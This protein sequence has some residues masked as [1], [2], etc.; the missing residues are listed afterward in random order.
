[1]TKVLEKIPKIELHE[2]CISV[3]IAKT[4]DGYCAYCPELDLV[5]ELDTIDESFK[6]I[7][8][9]IKDYVK[10]Y[11]QDFDLYSNSPNRAHHLPY[12][13]RITGCKDDFE[14]LSITEIRYGFV[15]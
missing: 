6:D 1:M 2:K 15:R 8:E 5:T 11:M 9:A 10:E 7:I 13:E 3:I 14:L 12:I 4:K